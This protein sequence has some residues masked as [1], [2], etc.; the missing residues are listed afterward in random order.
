VGCIFLL[1]FLVITHFNFIDNGK[2]YG[3][4]ANDEGNLGF[5]KCDIYSPTEIITLK[6]LKI[7]DIL[8]CGYSSFNIIIT[9]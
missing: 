2:I 4:G 3:F 1:Q 7:V 8:N 5:D 6:D 9:K